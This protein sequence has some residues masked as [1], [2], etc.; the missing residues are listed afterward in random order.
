MET[1][2]KFFLVSS[3]E[4]YAE[5]ENHYPYY[6]EN[7]SLSKPDYAVDA[8]RIKNFSSAPRHW[9]LRNPAKGDNGYMRVLTDG[10]VGAVKAAKVLAF[11]VVPA[12]AIC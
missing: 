11:G 3:E 4:V 10:G 1:A 7:S 2:D 5:G 6:K 12:C 9:W 8:I